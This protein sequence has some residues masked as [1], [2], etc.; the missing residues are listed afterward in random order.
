MKPKKPSAKSAAGPKTDWGN[1]ADWY[2]QL[3]GESGSEYHREVVIPGV[4]RLLAAAPGDKVIDG[5]SG[6]G[7]FHL[8]VDFSPTNRSICQGAAKCRS[9]DRCDRGMGQPQDQPEWPAGGGR[10]QGA[11]GDSNVYG[12]PRRE[13]RHVPSA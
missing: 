4:L 6:Q 1:V 12:D 8:H 7:A 3:V 11:V 13:D 2:D 10:K 5:A 9:L